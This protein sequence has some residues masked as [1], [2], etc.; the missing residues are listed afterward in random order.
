MTKLL[1]TVFWGS[2]SGAAAAY[3]LTSQKGKQLQ[4][5]VTDF[6]TDYQESPEDYNQKL[7][8]MV[9]GYKDKALNQVQSYKQQWETGELTKEDLLANL[10][11]RTGEVLDLASDGLN[12]V[13]TKVQEELEGDDSQ[14]VADQ[15]LPKVG[16]VVDDIVI[17]YQEQTSQ[18]K[19]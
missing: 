5:K 14:D 13:K 6:V 11:E 3:L 8:E 15:Q 2:L 1:K 16:V 7:K 4:G 12:Q 18:E 9:I 10:K 17:E 19:E